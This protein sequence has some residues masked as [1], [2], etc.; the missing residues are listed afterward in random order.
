MR[1]AIASAY[2]T[3]D[4]RVTIVWAPMLASDTQ[5]AAKASMDIFAD[6]PNVT[7]FWDPDRR[8][9][10]AYRHDVFPRASQEMASS[11]PEDHFFKPYATGRASD[12]PE[13]DI[14]MFFEPASSWSRTPPTPTSWLRQTARFKTEAGETESL[15]WKNDYRQPPIQG[16]VLDQLQ[17]LAALTFTSN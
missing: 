14:Y 9:G 11:L 10:L 5:A 7:Q 17:E 13:W 6:H 1:D 16:Q 8:A 2:S 4:V 3:D 15:M 12:Q